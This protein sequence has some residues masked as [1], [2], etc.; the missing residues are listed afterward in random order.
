MKDKI[1][2]YK[3]AKFP[4]KAFEGWLKRTT[5][6]IVEFE[7]NGQDL[8]KIWISKEGEILHANLQTSIWCGLFVKTSFAVGK[9]LKMWNPDSHRWLSFP[10]LVVDKIQNSKTDFNQ[11][12]D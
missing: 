1:A 5:T 2:Q 7:D 6:Q 10:A 9:C 3:N 8:L 12:L 4:E 11:Y